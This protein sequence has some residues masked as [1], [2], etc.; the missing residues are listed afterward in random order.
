[1]I[2]STSTFI[3]RL[4][5][6]FAGCVVATLAQAQ[7]VR[8]GAVYSISGPGSFLGAPE[9]KVLFDGRDPTVFQ[10][11]SDNPVRLDSDA[12]GAFARVATSTAS[13]GVKVASRSPGLAIAR[14]GRGGWW[15]RGRARL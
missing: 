12:Q 4:A 8:I 15:G 9:D 2:G 7:P 11:S 5:A 1:M 13:T 14:G 10:A 3:K 6:L